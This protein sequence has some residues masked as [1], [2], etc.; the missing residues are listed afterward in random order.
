M[1][2]ANAQLEL[3]SSHIAVAKREVKESLEIWTGAG[4][5]RLNRQDADEAPSAQVQLSQTAQQRLE[6]DNTARAVDK[7]NDPV[8]NDPHL[9]MMRAAIEMLTG[10]KM[11]VINAPPED[12]ADAP[13]YGLAYERHESYAEAETTTFSAQG[14]VQTADGREIGFTLNLSMSRSYYEENHVS[15]RMGAAV[16]DPLVLNFSGTA[17][18]LSDS[19]FLFDLD[20]DSA[21]DNMPFLKPGSAFLVFDRNQDGKVN[22]GRELFGALT[23]D[24]FGELAALDGDANGW[25]DENDSLYAL[26]YVWEK[27]AQGQDR[28]KSLRE[29]NVGA[30]SLA[31]ADTPFSIKD[32]DNALQ[33]AIHSS[34]VFLEETGGV[35][36]IQKIDLVV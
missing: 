13:G 12:P 1:K 21:M 31:R 18:E 30:I 32:K 6:A 14:K 22:D 2:I 35:G 36:T 3:A 7:L 29:A 9:S 23:G 15:I 19:R 26:L 25:I 34:G 17:A 28:L 24:G 11:Q 10:R 5:P 16:K 27:S 20:A 33:G 8:D 4:G